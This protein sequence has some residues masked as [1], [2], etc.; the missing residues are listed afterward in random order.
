MYHLLDSSK[1]NN[2]NQKH[3]SVATQPPLRHHDA[4]KFDKCKRINNNFVLINF[5][6]A[7][8]L[9]THVYTK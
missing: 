8:F 5:C 7:F 2:N 9:S 1:K 4:L 6:C 3:N